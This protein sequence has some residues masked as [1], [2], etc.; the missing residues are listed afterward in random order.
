M[1]TKLLI[2]LSRMIH[3]YFKIITNDTF[4]F[5]IIY[6]NKNR[7]SGFGICEKNDRFRL[8]YDSR[9]HVYHVVFR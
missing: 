6:Y 4:G 8:F 3:P 2:W 9:R 1:M 5:F 7:M